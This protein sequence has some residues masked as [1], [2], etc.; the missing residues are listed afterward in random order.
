MRNKYIGRIIRERRYKNMTDMKNVLDI[1]KDK[2]LNYVLPLEYCIGR[3]DSE[4]SDVIVVIHL[5]YE[6]DL[7]YYLEFVDHIPQEAFI[8]FTVSVDSMR[9][10]LDRYINEKHPNGKVIC[11]ENRGRDISAL[12]VAA[13]PYILQYKY[14]CFLHDK[15]TSEERVKED[16]KIFA[17]CLWHNVVG[18]RYYIENVLTTFRNNQ[19]IGILAPPESISD[20][21]DWAYNNT[22]FINYDITYNFLKKEGINCNLNPDKKPITLGTVFWARTDALK[23]LFIHDWKYEE[24][25]GEPLAS[26]GTISHAIERCF[27][28]YAQDAGYETGRIISDWYAGYY[29]ERLQEAL[30]TSFDFFRKEM[31]IHH[32]FELKEWKKIEFHIP[33][34]EKF[35]T[36]YIYGAGKIGRKCM[37]LLAEKFIKVEAF[38]VT[39]KNDNPAFI[40]NIPVVGLDDL[41]PD[42]ESCVVLALGCQ[43]FDQIKKDLEMINF[44]RN[45]VFCFYREN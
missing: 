13:K 28:Y 20:R 27:A 25:D 35:R 9:S 30:I 17:E 15:S 8:L 45:K 44:D 6:Q 33:E 34:V 5:F 31:N 24:F 42:D 29:M 37:Q 22:W 4:M 38:V 10:K 40:G 43:Y 39:N 16:I 18:S 19:N 21:R 12:L 14:L 1:R 32:L 23:K 41:V 2:N 36:V 3:V 11:K 26:D 7:E